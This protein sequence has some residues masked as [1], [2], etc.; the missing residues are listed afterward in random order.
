[1]LLRDM[2]IHGRFSPCLLYN[3]ASMERR[4]E[5]IVL[6]LPVAVP[7]DMAK[8]LRVLCLKYTL[9]GLQ[10]SYRPR[11]EKEGGEPASAENFFKVR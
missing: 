7:H 5:R 6:L 1:M 11:S 8:R 2:I 9:Q 10:D 3:E 4:F